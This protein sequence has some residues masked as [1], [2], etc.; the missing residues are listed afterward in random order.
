M[1]WTNVLAVWLASVWIVGLALYINEPGLVVPIPVLLTTVAWTA[2]LAN[3]A[4][5]SKALRKMRSE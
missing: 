3:W 4:G 1:F 2:V 5:Y